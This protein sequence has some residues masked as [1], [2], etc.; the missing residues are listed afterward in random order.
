MSRNPTFVF[1]GGG[2]GGHLFPGF[3]VAEE[4]LGR[5]PQARIVFAGSERA[6]ERRV[7]GEREFERLVLPCENLR[8]ARRRPWRFVWNNLR[9]WRA[10]AAWVSANAPDVVFGL[11]GFAS[12]PLVW[13]A[14]RRGVPVVLLEQNVV[15]GRATRWLSRRAALICVSFCPTADELG[16]GARIRVTGNPVRR[17]IVPGTDAPRRTESASRTL[18]ILG[19]SQGAQAVNRAMLDAAAALRASLA[20]WRIVHQTG[21]EQAES[22]RRRYHDLRVPAIVEPFF[23][24]LPAWYRAADLAV[25]RAGATTLAE[26]ACAGV[27]AVIVPYP[28]AARDH[29]RHNARVFA[30]AGAARV[31]EQRPDPAR[32]ADGLGRQL[33]ELIDSAGSR[34]RMRRAMHS[35]ARPHAASA[36]VDELQQ[37]LAQT[38]RKLHPTAR[39]RSAA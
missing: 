12:A 6:I 20:G 17:A 21:P 39:S 22:V 27:P 35:L 33:L 9:A 31:V 38:P 8:T 37:L 28:Q 16:G 25:T 10:A 23:D 34:N 26:L 7:H 3:A 11:G 32:T 4:L 13:A 15:A 29:Q 30:A 5:L 19:G 1:A 18:L 2:T 14:G 24:D 36:V